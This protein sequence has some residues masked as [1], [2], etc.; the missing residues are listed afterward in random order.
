M[1]IL[2]LFLIAFMLFIGQE[3]NEYFDK[4]NNHAKRNSNL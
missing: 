4:E 1:N 2:I 3:L